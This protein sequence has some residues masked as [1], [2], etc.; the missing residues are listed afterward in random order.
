MIFSIREITFPSFE[1]RVSRLSDVSDDVGTSL[2]PLAPPRRDLEGVLPRVF[3]RRVV[4]SSELEVH[5]SKSPSLMDL[6]NAWQ[7]G[8]AGKRLKSVLC[9]GKNVDYDRNKFAAGCHGVDLSRSRVPGQTFHRA[10]SSLQP[11][12]QTFPWPSR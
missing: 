12:I 1:S 7:P 4:E 9:N 10:G 5:A 6:R 2:A 8:R 11:V 3:S